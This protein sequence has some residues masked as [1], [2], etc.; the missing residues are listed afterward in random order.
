MIKNFFNDTVID[1]KYLDQKYTTEASEYRA[2]IDRIIKENH[3]LSYSAVKEILL[4]LKDV[5]EGNVE[6][7]L[8]YS[9]QKFNLN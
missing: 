8:C 1:T 6:E 7:Y 5:K 4:G 9:N 2:T 3:E